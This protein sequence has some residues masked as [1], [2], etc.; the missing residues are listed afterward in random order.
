MKKLILAC[1]ILASCNK[2]DIQPPKPKPNLFIR[3]VSVNADTI[4]SKIIKVS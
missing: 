1:L 4:Y 2:K 3:I